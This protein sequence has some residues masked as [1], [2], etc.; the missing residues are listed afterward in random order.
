MGSP[1]LLRD[2]V[3]AYIPWW[4]PLS[5]AT[6]SHLPVSCWNL[7][8]RTAGVF[9]LGQVSGMKTLLQVKD[10]PGSEVAGSKLLNLCLPW[11]H[12]PSPHRLYHCSPLFLA[13]RGPG[14][15]SPCTLIPFSSPTT[16]RNTIPSSNLLEVLHG[17]V[18]LVMELREF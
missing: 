17:L 13:S 3:T 5:L 18:L 10:A 9:S 15:S 12:G 14:I 16:P 1:G 11:H 4:S 7:V 6:P 8:M 2:K